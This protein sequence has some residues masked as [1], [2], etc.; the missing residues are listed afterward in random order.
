MPLPFRVSGS[1]TN[2]VLGQGR[3]PSGAAAF[4]LY[5]WE[6]WLLFLLRAA[7]VSPSYTGDGGLFPATI[8]EVCDIRTPNGRVKLYIATST[9]RPAPLGPSAQACEK[10]DVLGGPWRCHLAFLPLPYYSFYP[11]YCCHLAPLLP[12]FYS[13]YLLSYSYYCYSCYCYSYYCY[14]Y[15]SCFTTTATPTTC[16]PSL[17]SLPPRSPTTLSSLRLALGGKRRS[18]NTEPPPCKRWRKLAAPP[19]RPTCPIVESAEY[20][21]TGGQQFP[22]SRHRF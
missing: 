1:P 5:M 13:Y 10:R 4:R 7:S 2:F 22:K 12:A 9:C 3:Q 16:F 14:C 20:G 19:P 15:Y 17:P 18:H 21:S 6:T 8:L 11:Y